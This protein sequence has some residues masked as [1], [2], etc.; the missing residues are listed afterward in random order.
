MGVVLVALL[1]GS[2]VILETYEG[3]LVDSLDVSLEQQ[4]AD[5]VA[6][7][8]NGGP[9]DSLTTVLQDEAF[10]WIGTKDG[11][12]T[13]QGGAIFP[14]E[15]PVPNPIG[16]TMDLALLVE[17]RKP[18]E[19]EQERMVLRL[20]SGETTEG[21]V[22]LAGAELEVIDDAVG[23]LARLFAIAVPIMVA[24]VGAL[25][26]FITGRALQPVGAIR[27]QAERISGTTLAE[28]VPVPDSGDEIEDLGRTVNQM[29]GRIEH[30]DIAIRQF[31]SDA[32][33]E[34]K[35]PIANIRA[36]VETRDSDDPRWNA[37]RGKI[38]S[39]TDRLGG[40]VD[41]LLFLATHYD[42]DR[43]ID[44]APVALDELL[45]AEA[46]LVSAT[47]ELRVDLSDVEPITVFGAV[48][49]L[50]RAVRNLVDNATRHAERRIAFGLAKDSEW[51]VLSI[52]DDGPGVPAADRDVV[53]ERFARLDE[54][55]ARNDGGTGL[56]L[57]IVRQIAIAHGGTVD[58]SDADL[59][60]ARFELRL[61]ASSAD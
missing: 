8:E 9:K 13:A 42:E 5:R 55:R 18:N 1:G 17:E 16:T 46:E 51:V 59:G 38:S 56:G 60:G 44:L 49:D 12:V 48:A 33:H 34:L 52:A 4:V 41:N 40:L 25:A 28:R 3:Q 10:V 15:N 6:L 20:A 7:L 50:E 22:V 54:A 47:N 27:R 11:T 2:F 24:L 35:S 37:T 21:Q 14:L 19:I 39:E 32:S 31:S 45:F 43:A 57:N 30:H 58:I 29:L 26:W 36:L 61:P 23:G 53:F